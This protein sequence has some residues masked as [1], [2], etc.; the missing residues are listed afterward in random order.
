[1][2]KKIDDMNPMEL[3]ATITGMHKFVVQSGNMEMIMNF[4]KFLNEVVDITS[5]KTHNQMIMD[6]LRKKKL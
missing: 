4:G 2:T 3:S 5:L 6:E 1:M